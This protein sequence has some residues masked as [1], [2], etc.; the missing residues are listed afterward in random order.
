MKT[1]IFAGFRATKY[2]C[3]I[4]KSKDKLSKGAK[5]VAILGTR[6]SKVKKKHPLEVLFL[7]AVSQQN[8]RLNLIYLKWPKDE[9]F[10]GI[11]RL[12]KEVGL[13]SK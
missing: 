1:S 6:I 12:T 5:R 8:Q 2:L 9:A 3:F 7:E 10:S 13:P 4:N 11:Y